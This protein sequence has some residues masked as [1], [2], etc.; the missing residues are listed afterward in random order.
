MMMKFAAY[1][2]LTD[3]GD[4]NNKAKGRKKVCD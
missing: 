4:E 1:S 3:N 2:F